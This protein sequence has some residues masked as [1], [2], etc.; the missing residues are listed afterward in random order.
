MRVH[1]D[2]DVIREPSSINST[3]ENVD[4]EVLSEKKLGLAV[5]ILVAYNKLYVG[6]CE[7]CCCQQKINDQ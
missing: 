5:V 3:Y 7:T 6:A 1:A 2:Q 4:M